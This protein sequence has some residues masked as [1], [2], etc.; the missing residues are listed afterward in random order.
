[1]PC[2]LQLVQTPVTEVMVECQDAAVHLAIWVQPVV[3]VLLL[4]DILHAKQ[5]QLLLQVLLVYQYL[6]VIDIINGRAR[7]R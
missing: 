3:P 5:L 7:A 2:L 1:M 4:L 6:A